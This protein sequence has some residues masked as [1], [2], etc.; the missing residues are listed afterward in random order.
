MAE[1][2][3]ELSNECHNTRKQFEVEIARVETMVDVEQKTAAELELLTRIDEE[4]RKLKSKASALKVNVVLSIV[5]PSSR[6][7]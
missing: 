2:L 5:P 6:E 1:D 3:R 4:Y 7:Y